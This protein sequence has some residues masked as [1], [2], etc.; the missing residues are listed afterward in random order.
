MGLEF[1]EAQEDEK[2]LELVSKY[3]GRSWAQ[4]SKVFSM[5]I[6]VRKSGKQCRDR[7]EPP[8]LLFLSIFKPSL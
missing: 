3:N 4:I 8:F 6:G 7:Y 1:K 2:L 5:E